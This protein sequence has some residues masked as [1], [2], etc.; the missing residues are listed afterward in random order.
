[1]LLKYTSNESLAANG[2]FLLG[3]EYL[4]PFTV[5]INEVAI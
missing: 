2:H 1:M 3:S 5:L 4:A